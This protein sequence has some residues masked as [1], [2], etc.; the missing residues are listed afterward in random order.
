MASG[1]NLPTSSFKSQEDASLVMISTIFLRICL[2]WL[3]CAYA[4]FLTCAQQH[5]IRSAHMQ[6][7]HLTHICTSS[8]SLGTHSILVQST[9]LQRCDEGRLTTPRLTVAYKWFTG[10]DTTSASQQSIGAHRT[11]VLRAPSRLSH[12]HISFT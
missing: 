12:Y 11:D 2:I 8:V 5:P 4:V 9:L 6:F 3:L 10:A 1:M 7:Y